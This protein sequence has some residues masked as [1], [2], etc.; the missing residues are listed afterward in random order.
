MS[1]HLFLDSK[2]E[3]R[4]VRFPL[5]TLPLIQRLLIKTDVKVQTYMSY[6]FMLMF[7]CYGS[8]AYGIMYENRLG[9]TELRYILSFCFYV[10]THLRRLKVRL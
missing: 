3:N 7:R 8:P 4:A 1:G 5:L 9:M 6:R 10:L 2:C